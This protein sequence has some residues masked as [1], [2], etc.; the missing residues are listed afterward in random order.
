MGKSEKEKS[1][2][3]GTKEDNI[4]TLKAIFIFIVIIAA[5]FIFCQ[6]AIK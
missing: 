5:I 6:A 3:I 1:E 2:F 4:A